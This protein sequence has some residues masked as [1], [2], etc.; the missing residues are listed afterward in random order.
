LPQGFLTIPEI[1]STSRLHVVPVAALLPDD[2][3]AST[4]RLIRKT[5]LFSVYKEP[6]FGRFENQALQQSVF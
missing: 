6:R 2:T 5:L 1:A 3:L 4:N